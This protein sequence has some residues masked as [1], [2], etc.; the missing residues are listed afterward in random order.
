M[1]LL[2]TVGVDMARLIET[3]QQKQIRINKEAMKMQEN[4]RKHKCKYL[5]KF[6]TSNAYYSDI[7]YC[8]YIC[9]KLERRGCDPSVCEHWR[10]KN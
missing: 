5:K 6:K 2:I 4:C 10:D 8:N 1:L 3:E 9:E 7:R